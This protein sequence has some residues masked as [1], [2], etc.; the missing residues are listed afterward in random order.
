MER[1][2]ASVPSI[3]NV[4]DGTSETAD[5]AL[6]FGAWSECA[7]EQ[8]RAHA[9]PVDLSGG[10]LT[11]AVS[12]EIWRHHLN[13]LKRQLIKRME[14]AA[15]RRVVSSIEFGVCP[16]ALRP[17]RPPAAM[18]APVEPAGSVAPSLE[19]AAAG[20]PDE[21]LRTSFLAAAAVCLART[22]S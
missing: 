12:D 2:F 5:T 18:S 19:K 9:E 13:G 11:I 15:G 14:A 22:G 10:R 16:E 3:V 4:L 1:A 17:V 8:L 7:G 20:I 6:V 21:G